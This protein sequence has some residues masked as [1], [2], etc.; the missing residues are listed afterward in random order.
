[1]QMQSDGP[2]RNNQSHNQRV[3]PI[4]VYP[5]V[6]LSNFHARAFLADWRVARRCGPNQ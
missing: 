4:G 3:Y 2:I 1:M 5:K 6:A